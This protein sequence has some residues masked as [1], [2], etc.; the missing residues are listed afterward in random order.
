L[1][2]RRKNRVNYKN[3]M[4]KNGKISERKRITKNHIH[5]YFAA[6]KLREIITRIIMIKKY[7]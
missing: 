7:K 4:K 6:T 1:C 5:M 2:A 3:L